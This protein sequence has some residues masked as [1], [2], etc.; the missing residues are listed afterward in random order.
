MEYSVRDMPFS[1]YGSY[2]AIGYASGGKF[3][4]TLYLRS[5][6]GSER[7]RPLFRVTVVK[8][9][10]EIP[11]AARLK[12]GLMRVYDDS[13]SILFE[14]TFSDARTLRMRAR[15]CAVRLAMNDCGQYHLAYA[16]GDGRYE[17]NAASHKFLFAP[18]RGSLDVQAPWRDM[19]CES[20]LATF[21]GEIAISEYRNV[22]TGADFDKPFDECAETLEADFQKFLARQLSVPERYE[23]LREKAALTNWSAV[24]APEG[25]FRRD[26]MLMSKNWM[27]NVW[28]WDHCFNA[29]AL[30]E[31]DPDLAWAQF[32][33]P[34]DEQDE[35]GSLPDC[36]C[37]SDIIRNFVKPPIHGLTL[38]R[39]IKS[40]ACATRER[41][42]KIYEPLA[43]WT[44]WWFTYRD[45]DSDGIPQYNHGNDSGWD[46][47]TAFL[48]SP[49]VE[50][51][52]LAAFLVLQLECLSE[53]AALLGWREESS[54]R[55][56]QAR[57]LTLRLIKHFVRDG[58]LYSMVN[59]SH[60]VA[61]GDT[62]LNFMPLIMGERLPAHIRENMLAALK[63]SGRFLTKHGFATESVSSKYYV[64]DGY[65]RGPIW[66]PSTWLMIQALDACSETKL[67]DQIAE[68]FIDMCEAGG[69]SEN[70]DA[71]TGAGLRDRAYT[72]SSSVF[73]ML[74]HRLKLKEG[75]SC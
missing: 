70:Y 18:L 13:D 16:V 7:F 37:D 49:T 38:K 14:A 75:A 28:S 59:G 72:W 73:L 67:A 53:A 19:R 1:V 15:D 35:T 39:L 32:V 23:G 40:P 43:R 4:D 5:V 51:C 50:G 30:A 63:Q 24:V 48:S 11:F 62:L 57:E 34:F 58:R 27:N 3:G 61:D 12:A 45:Y 22:F 29:L 74:A 6:H 54:V 17:I 55:A 60:D 31:A 41:L 26:A 47:S 66:A 68:A 8:D 65:W 71:L 10:R 42:E 2:F 20:I 9:G 69:F 25:Y 64:P 46:N 44:D 21:E 52:D 56:E 36:I 33:L